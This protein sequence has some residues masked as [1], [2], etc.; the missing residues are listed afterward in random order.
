VDALFGVPTPAIE[1]VLVVLTVA[2]VLIVIAPALRR[3]SLLRM[4]A[5]NAVRRPLRSAVIVAGLMLST[6]VVSAAF[7]TGDA[8]SLT[9][10]SLVTGSVGAVDETI[11]AVQLDPTQLSNRSVS[12]LTSGGGLPQLVSPYFPQSEYDRIAQ[13]TANSSAIAGL[14]P[15]ILEQAPV[16]GGASPLPYPNVGV[17]GLAGDLGRG[18][19]PLRDSAGGQR[20]TDELA[21]NEVFLNQAA[22]N[23]LGA[24]A[25]T[26][27][28]V[29]LGA[30]PGTS[31]ATQTA[32]P[33]PFTVRAVLQN[34]TIAGPSPA[35]FFALSRLQALRGE[36]EQINQIAVV[37]RCTISAAC[38]AQAAL[39]IR[40]VTV[41]RANAET[42]RASLNSS[43]GRSAL[44]A[45]I[46]RRS[47]AGRAQIVDLKQT[48]AVG[49]ITDHLL[50]LLGDPQI[51]GTLRAAASGLP[52]QGGRLGR[53]LFRMNPVTVVEVKEGAL[54]DANQYA[55]LLT[56]SFLVLG[57]FSIAASLLLV[58]LV[59]VLLAAERRSEMG[60]GRA[61]GLQRSHLVQ[62]FAVEGL[63]YALAAAIFGVLAGIVTSIVIV[64]L[65]ARALA[66]YGVPVQ[67]SL[68]ARSPLIAFCA[69]LSV[70]LLTVLAAAW[71]VSRVNIVEAIRG[72]PAEAMRGR[73]V[74]SA[75]RAARI[76]AAAG[77]V[78]AAA[79]LA[80][81]GAG[82]AAAAGALLSNG[83]LPAAI[84]APLLLLGAARGSYLITGF[85]WTLLAIG[86]ALLLRWLLLA[87]SWPGSRVERLTYSLAAI[88]VTAYWLLPSSTFHAGGRH[89]T[90][91]RVEEF[92][93]A[94]VFMVLGAVSL[95]AYN[96]TE[97]LRAGLRLV[98]RGGAVTAA[99]KMA[100]AYPLL[101]RFRTGMAVAM[102][103]LVVF[104][105][106]VSAV[107]LESAH[108]AYVR[109]E[110]PPTG[111][112]ITA[113]VPASSG[114][115][116]IATALKSAPAVT[117]AAFS[118]AGSEAQFSA[119]LIEPAASA[120][121]WR[122]ATIH[123]ADAGLLSGT[124]LRL[125]AR[126]EGYGSDA[127]VWNAMLTTP[128]TALVA[129]DSLP[130]AG[131][132]VFD[133][134]ISAF[135]DGQTNFA[136]DA[137]WLRDGA[138]RPVRLTV[139]GVVD[140]ATALPS[141]LLTRASNLSTPSAVDAKTNLLLFQTAAG[142]DPNKAALGLDLSFGLQ[143]VQTQVVGQALLTVQTVRQLLD[144]LLEGF[145]GLGLLSG[146]AALGVVSARA[147]VER[148]Q[149]IGMLR[150]IGLQRWH[151]QL[152]FLIESA[153]VALLGIGTGTLLGLLLARNVVVFLALRFRELQVAV[154]WGEVGL[155]AGAAFL[156]ALIPTGAAAWRAG[157]VDPAEALRYE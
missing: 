91:G 6:L 51:A 47:G 104:T 103:A 145:V 24:Q 63:L 43:N 114:L 86:G 32:Q 99:L 96:L 10:R 135:A 152:S 124:P 57:L 150:A 100:A 127:A 93:V 85:G 44:Q 81:G 137:V 117:P 28:T 74:R 76:D 88:A 118:G 111:Y 16:A 30:A 148:R 50:Y 22:A 2:L 92:A 125:S 128:G 53:T 72:I 1:R 134:T 156:A 90:L 154:P 13:G 153:L 60:I 149:E 54:Q 5:R 98:R 66:T 112:N 49:H 40:R 140:D 121:R 52:G 144:Y 45:L 106:V 38:S 70:T 105:M 143:G 89:L 108:Q 123:L 17:V 37:N 11:S 73:G 48:V 87:R 61:I 141:G 130:R 14:L 146:V 46:N 58:F 62:T 41:D 19:Q 97:P 21:A 142:E 68:T 133:T 139:I 55:S 34:G 42:V 31:G 95:V 120:A 7:S 101:H 113:S 110:R 12:D 147:V 126:A 23:L 35:V 67:Q 116:D 132:T 131:A 80:A 77:S 82:L 83:I 155:I 84:G 56:S 18:F 39:D 4:G 64:H 94:G 25:G 136:P 107:L 79:R 9:V 109:R 29:F 8:M 129:R 20:S 75:M 15:M 33:Q 151:V 138:G 122:S 119:D 59:F 3:R 36:P 26:P 71:R 65:V 102:F 78:S 69:G 115:G 27:V 157:R